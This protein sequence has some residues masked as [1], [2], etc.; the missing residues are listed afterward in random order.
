ML[1][2]IKSGQL[3]FIGDIHGYGSVLENLLSE[4]GYK[5]VGET[6]EHPEG[7]RVVFLGDYIDR[8]PE[9]EKTLQTVR[10]MV[11]SGNAYAIMGNHEYN[12]VCFYTPD[13][14]GD[15]LR[16]HT[17]DSGKNV[18]Q[19][20]STLDQFADD[21]EQWS[22]WVEWFRT[23]PFY[24]D[25]GAWR[26]V[27]AAWDFGSIG[28]LEG[29][30]LNDDTF[31][32][33]SADS[34]LW[35]FSAVENVLKGLEVELPDD[36]TFKDHNGNTR[37]NMRVRWWEDPVGK[38]YRGIIFPPSVQVP[39]TAVSIDT[40]GVWQSYDN[41]EP[42]VFFGHYWIPP[43]TKAEPVADNAACLDYSV[44]S[45]S[46]KLTA[47]RWDGEQDLLPDNFVQVPVLNR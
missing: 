46:G 5:N 45:P 28:R 42:P 39:D 24:I 13:G 33:R 32:H 11:E 2:T 3:D 43:E 44:A 21:P 9:V 23:L 27:H 29:E 36:I 26:A 7:R 14:K 18:R 38:N 37:Q 8:G 1:Q 47:Y 30:S 17:E 35:E 6:H 34:S 19:H 25:A 40:G 15:Y 4:L 16:S 22:E 12:A 41:N 31:L 20:Q 10:A